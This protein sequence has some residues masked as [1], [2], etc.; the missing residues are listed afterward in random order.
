LA[1]GQYQPGS[2]SG[3][4]RIVVNERLRRRILSHITDDR[5]RMMIMSGAG[6]MRRGGSLHG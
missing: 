3:G 6:D 5:W 1:P 4:A 2:Q